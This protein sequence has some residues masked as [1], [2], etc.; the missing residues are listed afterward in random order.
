MLKP[1]GIRPPWRAHDS[2]NSLRLGIAPARPPESTCR[3][4]PFQSVAEIDEECPSEPDYRLRSLLATDI[5]LPCRS[6]P[7]PPFVVL[8]SF[9]SIATPRC[10]YVCNQV[11]TH[12]RVCVYIRRR[13]SIGD[14]WLP[15]EER[16]ERGIVGDGNFLGPRRTIS[17]EIAPLRSRIT[18]ID[19]GE[20]R[21]SVIIVYCK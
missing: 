7:G 4:F 5:S 9:R 16:K 8:R 15:V 10:V 6:S 17:R 14:R 20:S 11:S 21:G 3:P 18:R 2:R 1:C 19:V 12:A 13:D